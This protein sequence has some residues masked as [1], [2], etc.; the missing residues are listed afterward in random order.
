VCVCVWLVK[1]LAVEQFITSFQ[2]TSFSGGKGSTLLLQVS[3]F[4][5]LYIICN[6]SM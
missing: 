6:I 3:F 1:V 5:Y 4:I 2:S